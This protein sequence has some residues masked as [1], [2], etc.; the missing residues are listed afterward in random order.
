MNRHRCLKAKHSVSPTV[1]FGL[2]IAESKLELP[3]LNLDSAEVQGATFAYSAIK[4]KASKIYAKIMSRPMT[5][6]YTDE[7]IISHKFISSCI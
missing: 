7:F 1:V 5:L 2:L 6:R 4:I 3:Y